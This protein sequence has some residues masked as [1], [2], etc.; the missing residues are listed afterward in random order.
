VNAAG[1]SCA[2]YTQRSSSK[3]KP[4]FTVQ[5][6]NKYYRISLTEKPLQP[7]LFVEITYLLGYAGRVAIQP[8]PAQLFN[9]LASSFRKPHSF[10]ESQDHYEG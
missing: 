2:A 6:S 5:V 8:I 3:L 7:I 9:S 10:F 4:Q 1:I